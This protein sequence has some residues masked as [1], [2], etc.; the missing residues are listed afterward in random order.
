MWDPTQVAL[1]QSDFNDLK[2]KWERKR[3]EAKARRLFR[4][5]AGEI[6]YRRFRERGFHEICGASYTRYR[7]RPGFR[8]QVM[9]ED[10]SDPDEVAYEMCAH[11]PYGVPWYDSMAVQHLML[12]S[13]K[14]TE[15][16]FSNIANKHN[17]HGPYPI[18][19]LTAAA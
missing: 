9:R 18:P 6:L 10:E 13:S 5:V 15:E 3:A 8:V 19:E 1:L 17:P 4:R 11:L 16:Q 12:T 14:K 7:L 2:Y